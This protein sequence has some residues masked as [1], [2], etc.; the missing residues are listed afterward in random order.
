ML[1]EV[2]F[3]TRKIFLSQKLNKKLTRTLTGFLQMIADEVIF[4][5]NSKFL[6]QIVLK[7]AL[8]V[9]FLLAFDKF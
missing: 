6:V 4:Q 5:T 7:R 8:V 9:T 3:Q 1:L 2:D